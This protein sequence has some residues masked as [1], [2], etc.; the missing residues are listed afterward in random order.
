VSTGPLPGTMEELLRDLAPRVLGDLTRRSGQF[1]LSEDAVQEALLAAA[2]QW[3]G[4]GIPDNP[5]SWLLTVADRRLTDLIRA[6]S[7]RRRRETAAELTVTAPPADDDHAADRD[8]SLRLLFLC[9]HPALSQPSQIAL[10]LRSVAGLTTAQ[11]AHAFLVPEATMA[12]RISRAKKILADHGARFQMPS[13]EEFPGRLGA[14]LH[15]LYLIFNEGYTA[16][17]GPDLLRVDLSSEAIRLTRALR[18]VLPGDGEITGLLS[19]MLLTDA[20][21]PARIDG[22]GALVPLEAQDRAAW[23]HD[24]IAE[25][26]ALVTAA[27]SSAPLGP[28]QVQAAIAAVHSEAPDTASTDWPQI[29]GLYALLEQISP[30]PVVTLNRAVAL[31]MV[32]G[33]EAGLRLLGGL[34]NDRKL[35]SQHRLPAL[36]GHLHEMAGDGDA[37]R[38]A[39]LAA[40]RRTTSLPEK[41]YLERKAAA[42]SSTPEQGPA[43]SA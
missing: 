24:M 23:N 13:A 29:L 41:R 12:Q 7:A 39:Y 43:S 38:A 10:T 25:G 20:R 17:S 18:H 36:R 28:Y 32:Y 19:L 4:T 16:S 9:C 14:V 21:R 33:P 2:T 11:I 42:L 37:A 31:A 40:A 15:V 30:S 27:L 3:P 1:D 26:I 34:D 35:A 8:D 22:N 5:R 6:D